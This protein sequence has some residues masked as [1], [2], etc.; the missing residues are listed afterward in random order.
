VYL[1][2]YTFFSRKSRAQQAQEQNRAGR[3]TSTACLIGNTDIWDVLPNPLLPPPAPP[4]V[5]KHPRWVYD[6]SFLPKYEKSHPQFPPTSPAAS[7]PPDHCFW[8][9]LYVFTSTPNPCS[10][11]PPYCTPLPSHPAP[12]AYHPPPTRSQRTLLL[13]LT[14]P[15]MTVIFSFTLF[16]WVVGKFRCGFMN[17]VR[18][19][20]CTHI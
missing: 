16:F 13:I 17:Y 1:L 9:C 6:I 3:P 11:A 18:Q 15:G 19:L 12:L 2:Q 14:N 4:G 8:H 7:A 10:T 20:P 5:L